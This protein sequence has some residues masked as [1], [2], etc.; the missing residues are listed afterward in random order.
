M[1]SDNFLSDDIDSIKCLAVKKRRKKGCGGGGGGGAGRGVD[2]VTTL[3]GLIIRF[4]NGN[5][6][7]LAVAD[8]VLADCG[9]VMTCLLL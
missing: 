2:A 6:V 4:H 8:D 7:D 5:N 9:G 1:T 3:I